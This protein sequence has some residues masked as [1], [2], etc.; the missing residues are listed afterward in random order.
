MRTRQ[1]LIRSAAE[2]FD[3]KGFAPSSL[4]EISNRVGVSTGALNFHFR[5]KRELGEAVESAAVE[6]MRCIVTMRPMGRPT[7]LQILVDT[8]HVLAR[9]LEGD[10]VFR[11]G[12]GLGNDV[13][14]C[15][16]SAVWGEWQAWVKEIL[17]TAGGAGHLADD[18]VLDDAWA[19]VATAV[20][21]FEAL[22][23]RDAHWR[24]GQ[25]VT[26]LWKLLL[27]RLSSDAVRAELD[28]SGAGVVTW[29]DTV[30]GKAC[31]AQHGPLAGVG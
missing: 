4:S 17:T 19:A 28:A 22:G 30:D 8:T 24:S 5:S 10:V 18:L 9:Q 23:R 14:W 26:R 3:E 11:A 21:G 27:P 16:G 29:A 2:A 12:F 13:T 15:A 31:P 25:T 20:A 7:P 6:T 1:D